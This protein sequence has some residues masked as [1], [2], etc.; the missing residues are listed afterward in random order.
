MSKSTRWRAQLSAL[1]TFLRSQRGQSV[2]E[3]SVL[4]ATLLGMLGAGGLYLSKTHPEMM[5]ALNTHV[6]G[7]YFT[8]SLPFP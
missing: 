4:L 5:N 2:V 1:R 6:R 8:L 3:S 7:F